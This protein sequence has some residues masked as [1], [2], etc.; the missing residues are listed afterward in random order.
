MY[1]ALLN[2]VFDAQDTYPTLDGLLDAIKIGLGHCDERTTLDGKLF[3]VPR[4]ISFASM[5]QTQF[6]QFFDRTVNLIITHILPHT[7]KADLEERVFEVLGEP[8]PSALERNR[9]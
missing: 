5:D 2:L 7:T 9:A 4:S 6:S 3:M 8:G 1:F